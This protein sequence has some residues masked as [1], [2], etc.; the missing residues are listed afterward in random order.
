[1]EQNRKITSKVIVNIL[2]Y[3]SLSFI[4]YGCAHPTDADKNIVIDLEKIYKGRYSFDFE[5]E[6]YLRV[7]VNKG[8]NTLNQ[9]ALDIYKK[10]NFIDF[11]KNIVRPT[12]YLYLNLYDHHGYFFYQLCYDFQKKE[13]TRGRTE[14]Y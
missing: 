13:F 10:F 14:Y 5:D 4:Y 2:I 8:S 11:D 9:D 1:L 3:I 6:F 7:Q 12:N